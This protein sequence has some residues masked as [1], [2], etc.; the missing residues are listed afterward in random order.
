MADHNLLGK[1][2]N[3]IQMNIFQKTTKL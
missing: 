2:I 3:E 1:L